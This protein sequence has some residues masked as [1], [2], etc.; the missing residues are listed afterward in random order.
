M[1]HGRAQRLRASV[2]VLVLAGL[3][4]FEYGF[5]LLRYW[6]YAPAEGDV[7]F[8][9]LPR[10]DLV[11][12]IEGTTGSPY[13]HCGVVVPQ[14]G[15]WVVVESIETVHSTPLLK[16]IRRG[17]GKRFAAY[18]LKPEHRRHVRAFVRELQA[19]DGR[20]YDFRYQMDDG[21][22]YCSE[23]VYKAYLNTTGE[24]LGVLVRMGDLNWRP[25]EETIRRYEVGEPPLDRR[26]ITPRDLARADQLEKVYGGTF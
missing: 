21:C 15:R 6:S 12:A 7:V 11:T 5:P 8:Q 17:R 10:C 19:F 4:F 18:R 20:P 9:S 2:L 13:S 3:A 22:I 14:D 23:L 26:M 25:Y 24:E 1:P 16:W